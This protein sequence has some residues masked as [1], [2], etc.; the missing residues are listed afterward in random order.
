MKGGSRDGVRQAVL[1]FVDWSLPCGTLIL[2][3]EV[4]TTP[5]M[6]SRGLGRQ[7]CRLVADIL[8]PL[9]ERREYRSPIGFRG[10]TAGLPKCASHGG[11]V[12]DHSIRLQ[13]GVW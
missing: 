1:C 11:A 7:P 5:F 4:V 2:L 3:G 10:L 9:A 6:V 13:C 12:V 8:I